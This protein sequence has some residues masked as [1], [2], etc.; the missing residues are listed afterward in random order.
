MQGFMVGLVWFLLIALAG[1]TVVFMFLYVLREKHEHTE[2]YI[3]D[4][5]G[6]SEK[7]PEEQS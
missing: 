1:G 7:T 4:T 3:P 2:H 5:T 6:A